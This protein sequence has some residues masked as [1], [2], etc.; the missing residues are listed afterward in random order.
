MPDLTSTNSAGTTLTV[1][2]IV[3]DDLDGFTRTEQSVSAQINQDFEWLIVDG[4]EL[5]IEG[6]TAPN[7]RCVWSE[8]RGIYPAMNTALK[9]ARG[10]FILYLN[11][12][13]TFAT[14]Q[15]VDQILGCIHDHRPIWLYGQASFESPDGA[16][17][18]PPPFDY[19]TEKRHYFSRGRFPPHQATIAQSRVLKDLGGFDESYK[20][21]ADYKIFLTLSTLADP[22]E[23]NHEIARFFQGG[24][25][26]VLWQDSLMEFRRA[27]HEV[28]NLRGFSRVRETIESFLL[29]EKMKLAR[30]LRRVKP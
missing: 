21:V 26:S 6:V 14:H 16:L 1:V 12:G 9:I 7:A 23:M 19:A 27:R 18:T 5:P 13:D 30:T 8:P 15:A 24:L 2:T 17:H 28:F 29:F 20:I 10:E 3:K 11:A 25:S 22:V 4:S